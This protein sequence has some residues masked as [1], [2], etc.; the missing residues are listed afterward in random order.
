MKSKEKLLRQIDEFLKT[1]K[2]LK[3]T[4]DVV[5]KAFFKENIDLLKSLLIHFLT[6]P[7]GSMIEKIAILDPELHPQKLSLIGIKPG[8][9]FV[10]D[11]KVRFKRVLLDGSHFMETV[12]VE[13][14]TVSKA[15]VMDRNL[16]YISRILSEQLQKGKD[17][18]ELSKVYSLLFVVETLKEFES[19]DDYYHV[20]RLLRTK[21]PHIL[22]S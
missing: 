14:Q 4:N 9:D 10:L 1:A 18:G 2:F 12:N 5:F 7:E 13:I 16:V 6:L 15:Y 8:K 11:L 19:V 17:Y 22:M 20:C 21:P 3:L